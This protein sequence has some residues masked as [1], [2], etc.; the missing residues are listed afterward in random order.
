MSQENVEIVVRQF[1][2][3]NVRDFAGVMD[4]WAEDVTLIVR[5]E[6]GPFAGDTATGK[7]AVGEWFADWF[8]E[9]G[10]DYHFDIEE[11]RVSG[12]RVFVFATH[13]GRGR[14]SGVPVELGSAYVYT[15]RGGQV[16]RVEIWADQDAREAA[17][18]AVGLRE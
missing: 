2:C 1:E 18:A 12:D 14:H 9:F 5:G 17:L 3:V 16:S 8:R 10:R 7:A 11:T 6:L 13:H 4:A 15:L